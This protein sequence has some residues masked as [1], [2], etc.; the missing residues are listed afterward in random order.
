MSPEQRQARD[1]L[2][3][4]ILQ[5][6]QMLAAIR[7]RLA[8]KAAQVSDYWAARMP[9]EQ[10]WKTV[11]YSDSPH[12]AARV[13]VSPTGIRVDMKTAGMKELIQSVIAEPELKRAA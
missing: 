8:D 2:M 12:A 13:T 11:K 5:V 10:K 9:P 4:E 3:A 7:E 1:E 6:E